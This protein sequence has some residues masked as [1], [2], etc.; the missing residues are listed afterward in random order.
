V[1]VHAGPAAGS[2]ALVD[3]ILEK[4]LFV[5]VD[6]QGHSALLRLSV[7]ASHTTAELAEAARTLARAVPSSV[8]TAAARGAVEAAR[9]ARPASGGVF[10]GLADAA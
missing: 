5:T 10:D 9:S 7:M 8:R 1:T 4:G 3:R 6:R 2:G